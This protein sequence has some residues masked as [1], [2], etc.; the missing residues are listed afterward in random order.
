M[1]AATPVAA[2]ATSRVRVLVNAPVYESPRT[3]A[4]VLGTVAAGTQVRWLQTAQPGWEEIVLRDGRSVYMPSNTLNVGGGS[5]PAPVTQPSGETGKDQ[6][7][8]LLPATVDGFL[9]TLQGGDLL[10]AGTYLSP[11]APTLE[12]PDL[13]VWG[14]LVGPQADAKVT[15]MEPV[16]GRGSDWRSVLVMDQVSGVQVQTVWEWSPL[17]QRWL[18]AGWE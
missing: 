13:G 6:S 3:T 16:P 7:L 12:E 2:P 18:L 14:A 15:R 4:K 10:R 11:Q 5:E 9:S 17:Q 8:S 1:T